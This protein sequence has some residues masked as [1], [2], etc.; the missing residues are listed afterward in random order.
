MTLDA[1]T[2]TRQ[3]LPG[4]IMARWLIANLPAGGPTGRVWRRLN[5]S[6]GPMC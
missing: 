3:D 4:S 5:G 2:V 6:W 1:Y